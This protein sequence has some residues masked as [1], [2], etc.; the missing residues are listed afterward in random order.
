[1]NGISLG[2]DIPSE[3]LDQFF[4]NHHQTLC[5]T[6]STANNPNSRWAS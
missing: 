6:F 1:M 2:R 5:F 4:Q 3:L